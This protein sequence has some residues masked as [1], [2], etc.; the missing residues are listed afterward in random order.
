MS[1]SEDRL[2]QNLNHIAGI[3]NISEILPWFNTDEK[4]DRISSYIENGTITDVKSLVETI[5]HEFLQ[6]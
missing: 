4:Q 3:G 5:K 6:R 1:Q 2:I